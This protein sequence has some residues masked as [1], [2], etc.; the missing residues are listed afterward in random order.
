MIRKL[1]IILKLMREVFLPILKKT[2]M[3]IVIDGYEAN[4]LQRLGSSQV[5]YELIKNLERIDKQNDYTILLPEKPLD[6]LPKT[7][8]G[9]RYKILKPRRLWTKIALPLFLFLNKKKIDLF[10][11]PTHY[12]PQY[13][14]TKKIVTIFDLSFL[15]FPEMFEK[16]DLWKL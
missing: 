11:S 16:S 5:A 15:H 4:V 2:D 14:P 13:C 8:D 3:R 12:L 9:F 7:R 10:F 1:M 6:D